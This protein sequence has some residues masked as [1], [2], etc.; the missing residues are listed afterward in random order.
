[1]KQSREF[2]LLCLAASSC[3]VLVVMGSASELPLILR[4]S[5]WFLVVPAAAYLVVAVRNYRR[6]ASRYRAEARKRFEE[7]LRRENHD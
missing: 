1:M 6:F 3:A 5:G 7:R 2:A 4:L